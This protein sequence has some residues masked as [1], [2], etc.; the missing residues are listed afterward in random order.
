MVRVG[1]LGRARLVH[2]GSSLFNQAR[3]MVLGFIWIRVRAL[4]RE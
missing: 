3:I 1:S 2:W 4:D